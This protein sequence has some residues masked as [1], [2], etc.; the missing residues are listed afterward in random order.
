MR[1]RRVC[2]CLR[3]RVHHPVCFIG[4]TVRCEKNRSKINS[5]RCSILPDNGS[6]YSKVRSF[7]PSLIRVSIDVCLLCIR[8]TF[9][10]FSRQKRRTPIRERS[11]YV[12][13]KFILP[14][15]FEM[16]LN[17]LMNCIE[18]ERERERERKQLKKRT[19]EKRARGFQI[20]YRL[21]EIFFIAGY[22]III[23]I[24]I[25]DVFS[26]LLLIN[27]ITMKHSC[28]FLS[29]YYVQFDNIVMLKHFCFFSLILF[30]IKYML[31]SN[32]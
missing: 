19:R 7:I 8:N 15:A 31:N 18:I 3:V 4:V 27:F 23:F 20:K 26:L 17:E 5:D 21:S 6:I 11:I 10:R 22:I 1:I 28:A 24:N 2:R 29:K 14:R 16:K 30:S 13:S 32:L 25:C 9:I 12:Q